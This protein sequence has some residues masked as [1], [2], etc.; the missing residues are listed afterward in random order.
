MPIV[1]TWPLYCCHS[2][3]RD[4]DQRILE[5]REWTLAIERPEGLFPHLNISVWSTLLWSLAIPLT[6]L[7][8]YLLLSKPR[9][10][11]LRFAS[12]AEA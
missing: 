10:G 12:L 2:V 6:F 7:S 8:A 11:Q 5:S 1:K 9:D 3:S 4:D